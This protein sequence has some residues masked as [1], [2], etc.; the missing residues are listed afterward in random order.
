MINTIMRYVCNNCGEEYPLPISICKVCGCD[1][2]VE[3]ETS[4][5]DDEYYP[6]KEVEEG[7]CQGFTPFEDIN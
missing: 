1:C 7:N 4:Q 2:G 3:E 6:Y 5:E